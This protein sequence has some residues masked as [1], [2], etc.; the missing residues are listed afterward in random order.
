M[1]EIDIQLFLMAVQVVQAPDRSRQRAGS[2]FP[3]IV[4]LVT[5]V[6]TVAEAVL[7]YL[8]NPSG[9]LGEGFYAL[10]MLAFASVGAL[11]ASRRPENPIG[12]LV[13]GGT[14]LISLGGMALEYSVYTLL[15]AP[16]ALPSGEWTL[17]LGGWIRSLGFF[18]LVGFVPLLFPSGRLPSPRWRR[19]A[20]FALG[21]TTFFT[22]VVMFSP[23]NQ[24]EL[25]LPP[26]ANPLGIAI[27]PDIEGPLSGISFLGMGAVILAVAASVVIR[28]RRS[29]GEERQQ[30]KWFAYAG[31]LAAIVFV[32]ILIGVFLLPDAVM[33][34]IGGTL[35]SLLLAG[36]PIAIGI[37]I[38]KYRL[39][40]IDLL[41]NRTLVYV[42]LTGI[43]AGIFAASITLTQRLFVTLTGEKSDAAT[44]LTTLIVVAAFEP[45]KKWLQDKVDKRFKEARD[46][47]KE[48]R[49]YSE[50]LN[51][52]V[53]V[54]DEE[55]TAKRFLQQ[56]SAAFDAKG[57]AVILE[58]NGRAPRVL[59]AGEWKGEAELSASLDVNGHHLGWVRLN[60]RRNGDAYSSQDQQILQDNANL[61]AAALELATKMKEAKK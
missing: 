36:F 30:L 48:L 28:F 41:I 17:W 9:F 19:V 51:E 16:H 23:T 15:T 31:V 39:Y 60:T 2:W 34:T 52:V 40:E 21:G 46:P 8:N 61:V 56:V 4:W 10:V 49:A 43:L 47:A 6:I 50:Q 29:V 11:V 32:I 12:W 57:G 1:V 22:L 7:A 27:P 59:E 45:L 58:G 14:C 35:F 54:F 55:Q 37:A 53:Q 33:S 5:I 38:L 13:L 18:I 26:L 3:W 44:V 20:W 25:R 42:P 24:M